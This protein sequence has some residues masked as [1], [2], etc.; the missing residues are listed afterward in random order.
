[1]SEQEG[2]R[3]PSLKTQSQGEEKGQQW[4]QSR[5]QWPPILSPDGHGG[6]FKVF[7]DPQGSGRM[8][9]FLITKAI[10]MPREEGGT[11]RVFRMAS[12]VT[13]CPQHC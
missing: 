4:V 5:S 8:D 11:S 10:Y 6:I 3:L 1:M 12:H 9:M 7:R 2:W 13:H